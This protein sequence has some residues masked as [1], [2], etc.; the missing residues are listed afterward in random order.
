MHI[1]FIEPAGKYAQIESLEM[2]MIEMPKY[3]EYGGDDGFR[4]MGHDCCRDDS[5][6]QDPRDGP[7]KP[8]HIPGDN[9][10]P[11]GKEQEPIGNLL[12]EVVFTKSG[13]L[14]FNINQ[15]KEMIFSYRP[16]DCMSPGS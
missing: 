5:T 14:F 9:H 1:F 8:H 6:W 7:W 13:F 11:N 10:D 15:I 12:L 2:Y 16:H 4:T 3:D